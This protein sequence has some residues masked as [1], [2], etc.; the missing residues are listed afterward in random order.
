MSKTQLFA[1]VL[2]GIYRENPEAVTNEL[3]G[4]PPEEI[5]EVYLAVKGKKANPQ[6][7][8]MWL[9]NL[10]PT[11][12]QLIIG[13]LVSDLREFMEEIVEEKLKASE[14]PTARQMNAAHG[15][16]YPTI[17]NISIPKSCRCSDK[18]IKPE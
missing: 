6:E 1:D 17:Y 4:L 5:E 3:K 14:Y 12:D 16:T 8:R 2:A 10:K 13:E 15:N 7:L 11:K 9:E 18:A